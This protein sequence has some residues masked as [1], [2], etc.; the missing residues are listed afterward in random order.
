[1]KII[2]ACGSISLVSVQVRQQLVFLVF[3]VFLSFPFLAREDDQIRLSTEFWSLLHSP[4]THQSQNFHQSSHS[5]GSRRS[6]G[7]RYQGSLRHQH[8]RL[9]Y[10]M[11]QIQTLDAPQDPHRLL[12]WLPQAL[13]WALLGALLW[14]LLHH[15]WRSLLAFSEDQRT[16]EVA[17][18]A[19]E[20]TRRRWPARRRWL[21]RPNT[22]G[23]FGGT[24]S[25]QNGPE[26]RARAQYMRRGPWY[27]S[28]QIGWLLWLFD[29]ELW[30][31]SFNNNQIPSPGLKSLKNDS[32]D[33]QC[34]QTCFIS[35]YLGGISVYFWGIG[36]RTARLSAMLHLFFL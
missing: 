13:L 8:H 23:S 15:L 18:P 19:A 11:A 30:K 27:P 6:Q 12:A 4:M 36:W 24:P 21:P 2:F 1:M 33:L 35:V 17:R 10:L 32:I 22:W 5:Q 31:I 3:L 7:S 34:L 20:K 9:N 14:D 28:T 25:R 26:A 29:K 16:W